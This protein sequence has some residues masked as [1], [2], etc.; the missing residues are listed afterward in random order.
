[1][2]GCQKQVEGFDWHMI[3]VIRPDIGSVY[4]NWDKHEAL[5]SH[6]ETKRG[7]GYVGGG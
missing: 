1:M 2:T 3:I 6:K 5:A 4:R 7:T